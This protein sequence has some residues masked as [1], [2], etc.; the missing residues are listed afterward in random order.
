MATNYPEQWQVPSDSNPD[1]SYIVSV[2]DSK[3]FQ[4]SCPAWTRHMPR[5][6]CKH[7]LRVRRGEYGPVNALLPQL[8]RAD[9]EQ[10]TWSADKKTLYQPNIYSMDDWFEITI[11]YDLMRAGFSYDYLQADY[12]MAKRLTE[13]RIKQ[14]I[15][16]N[17]RRIYKFYP[18][19]NARYLTI[20]W[21]SPIPTR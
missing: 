12:R 13:D 15:R 11:V 5:K 17:G 8:S 18:G 20:A 21:N 9:I 19:A 16:D 1:K 10:V 14:Y 4:C 6:D 2:T 3:E 7:I